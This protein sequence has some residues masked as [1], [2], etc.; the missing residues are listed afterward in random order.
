MRSQLY[1]LIAACLISS[2]TVTFAEQ[3]TAEPTIFPYV[4]EITGSEVYYHSGPG[5]NHYRCGRLKQGQRVKVIS[6]ETVW[7]RIVPPAG[8]FSWISKQYVEI[9]PANTK[10]GTVAGDNVRVWVGSD[11][12]LPIYCTKNDIRLSTGEKVTLLGLEKDY[13]KIA[14]PAGAYRWVSTQQTKALD[15]DIEIPFTP[16]IVDEQ[17]GVTEVVETVKSIDYTDASVEDKMLRVYYSLDKQIQAQRDKPLSQQDYT[18]I[19]RSLTEIAE[20]TDAGKA[21]RYADYAIKQIQGFELAGQVSKALE[22]QKIQ[23]A[24]THEAIEKARLARLKKIVDLSKYTAI[25]TLQT[26]SVYASGANLLYH[27]LLDDSGKTICYALATGSASKIDL[28][29]YLDQKV[30]LIGT[31]QP[32]LQTKSALVQYSEITQIR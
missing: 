13:Y 11:S 12:L 26:S 2:A 25:G 4:A 27:R 30:A 14:P 10:V 9:D 7:S 20:K 28:T 18:A 1:L 16:D 22:L 24:K 21:V 19:K 15:G 32:H 5:T 6:H 3:E 17:P 8:S 29:G 31:V 23:L